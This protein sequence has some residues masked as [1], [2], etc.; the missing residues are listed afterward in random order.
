MNVFY[1]RID[2]VNYG[3][4][5]YIEGWAVWVG[6]NWKDATIRQIAEEGDTLFIIMASDEVEDWELDEIPLQPPK[7]KMG[8]GRGR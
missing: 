3:F 6:N 4:E 7:G 5:G 1:E 2:P 8:W